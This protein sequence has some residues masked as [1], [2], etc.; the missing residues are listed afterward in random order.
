MNNENMIT[1][2][3]ETEL[4]SN[5][6]TIFS[7]DK[8]MFS[9]LKSDNIEDKIKLYNSLQKCDIR[10]NDIVGQEIEFSDIFIEEKPTHEIDEATG[11]VKAEN[12]KFRTIL[13]GTDGSTYVSSAYGVYNSLKNIIAIFGFPTSENPIKVKV[14]KRPTQSGRETLILVIVNA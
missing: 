8:K 14:A 7:S 2:R 4:I 9:T 3:E 5:D 13:F 11:E 10:I 12:R 6:I 1:K